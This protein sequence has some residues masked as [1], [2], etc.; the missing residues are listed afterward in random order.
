MLPGK[1]G[2]LALPAATTAK[3][4]V[5][6]GTILWIAAAL[7]ALGWAANGGTAAH[8]EATILGLTALAWLV[9][10]LDT[11]AIAMIGAVLMAGIAAVGGAGGAAE[12]LAEL[13]S[14]TVVL[15]LAALI[16]GVAITETGLAGKVAGWTAGKRAGL[17]AYLRLAAAI[18]ATTFLI[19]STAARAGVLAPVVSRAQERAASRGEQR[20][21][22]LMAPVVVVLA[23]F[24]SPLAAAANL[25][26]LQLLAADEA[27]S[28]GLAQWVVLATPAALAACLG[29]IAV[30]WSIF[31]SDRS[32][33]I[34]VASDRNNGATAPPR[35]AVL[36]T[37]FALL[38][39]VGLWATAGLHPFSPMLVAIAAAVAVTAPVVG[40]ISLKKALGRVDWPLILLLAAAGYL[41][42]AAQSNP[43]ID[44]AIHSATA[45]LS[46]GDGG[47]TVLGL[48]GLIAFSMVL[49]LAVQ[50]RSARAVLVLPVVLTVAAA[51]GLDARLGVL[52]MTAGI[53]FCVLTPVGS[54][55]LMVL[56]ATGDEDR[57]RCDLRRAAPALFAV[58][59]AV[60]LVFA[61]LLW[62][63]M[64]GHG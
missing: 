33:P 39:A 1:T 48:A 9:T 44:A 52:A 43:L 29:A 10:R 58:Q 32:L 54:K 59:F 51:S 11:T 55:A 62:P 57:W 5:P 8:L 7:G 22:A 49:H 45:G 37:G 23:A 24:S 12:P 64:L 18:F 35:R 4:G 36:V 30:I 20:A 42:I 53:G 17:P 47:P 50:S 27:T 31:G 34:P 21:I 60:I 3:A 63:S 61:H 46:A 25:I 41:A 40:V 6:S 16:L 15:I 38:A 28:I 2:A 19:P 56:A 14:D 26:A 13:G